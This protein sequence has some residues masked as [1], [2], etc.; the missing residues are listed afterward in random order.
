M[1]TGD[2]ISAEV[3]LYDTIGN[4]NNLASDITSITVTSSNN[5]VATGFAT[6]TE[7]PDFDDRVI[8][9]VYAVGT[10]PGS[11]TISATAN[12]VSGAIPLGSRTVSVVTAV[13]IV[14]VLPAGANAGE[15]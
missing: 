3:L 5:A 6:I 14:S 9:T 15:R 12:T 7:H 8:L 4:I 1:L 13:D 11:A 2:T 10:G